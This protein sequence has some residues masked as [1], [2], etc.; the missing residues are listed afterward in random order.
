[1]ALNERAICEVW[2]QKAI[3][4]SFIIAFVHLFPYIHRK[5]LIGKIEEKKTAS[6]KQGKG[7]EVYFA[8]ELH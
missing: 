1:M 8:A 7:Q 2:V 3:N 5:Y 6:N 4:P